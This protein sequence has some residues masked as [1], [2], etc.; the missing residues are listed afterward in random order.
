MYPL[1]SSRDVT[2]GCMGTMLMNAERG[3]HLGDDVPADMH[4]MM[5]A[6][7]LQ[8]FSRCCIAARQPGW[9]S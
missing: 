3:E 4:S 8:A 2:D 1:Y 5:Q 6:T 7:H 9:L